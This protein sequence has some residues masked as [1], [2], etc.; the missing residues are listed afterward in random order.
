MND[1]VEE[2]TKHKRFVDLPEDEVDETLLE[3]ATPEKGAYALCWMEMHPGYASLR[4]MMN[5]K[6]KVKT[7]VIGITPKGFSWGNRIFNTL[8]NLLDSFKHNASGPSSSTRRAPAPSS[9]RTNRWGS[10]PAAPQPPRTQPPPPPA[11]PAAAAAA[12]WA[13]RPPPPPLPPAMPPPVPT[14]VYGQQQQQQQQQGGWPSGQRPPPPPPMPPP[15]A[16]QQRPPPPPGPYGAP[17]PPPMPPQQQP[18]AFG[19]SAAQSQG[20]GRGRTLPAWMSQ[21]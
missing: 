12:S 10:K 1:Y 7:H 17:Q 8:E 6:S 13:R 11:P 18:P 9:A 14:A 21:G 4:Y 16:Y 15:A 2:V 19:M 5:S 20:R 3:K